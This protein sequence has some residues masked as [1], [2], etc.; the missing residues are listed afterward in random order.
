LQRVPS[1]RAFNSMGHLWRSEQVRDE[2]I[3]ATIAAL[4]GGS[5]L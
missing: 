3:A 2:A 4:R 1:Y 5:M